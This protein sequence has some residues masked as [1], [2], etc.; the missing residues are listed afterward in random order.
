MTALSANRD[1][2]ERASTLFSFPVAASTKIYQG[3]LV[4]INASGL[5]VPASTSTT[6]KCVGRAEFLADNSAGLASAIN[7]QVKRGCFKFTNGESITLANVGANAYLTDDQTVGITA[8]GK[9]IAGVIR[10]VEADGVWIEI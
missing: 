4:A 1:T 6:L 7:V 2:K 9:S 5:A 10:D 8:T 3:S